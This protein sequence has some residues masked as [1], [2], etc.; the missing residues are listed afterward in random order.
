MLRARLPVLSHPVFLLV[1][2]MVGTMLISAKDR[3]VAGLGMGRSEKDRE[4]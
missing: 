1:I 4:K 2:W 3:K